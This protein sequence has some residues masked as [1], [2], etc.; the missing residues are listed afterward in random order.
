MVESTEESSHES[1]GLSDINFTSVVKVEFSPGSWEEL[2]HVSLHLGLGHLLG[3]EENFGASLLASILIEDL[4]S[5][6]LTSSVGDWDGVVVEDVVHNIVLI[7]TEE[8]R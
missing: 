6:S 7:S 5:G 8:S 1:V 4:S 3:D 2:S